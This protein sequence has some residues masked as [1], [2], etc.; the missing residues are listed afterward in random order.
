MRGGRQGSG[1]LT[2]VN[3]H[4]RSPSVVASPAR[5]RPFTYLPV[6]GSD[7]SIFSVLWSRRS[8]RPPRAIL[9]GQGGAGSGFASP[10][11]V[12]VLTDDGCPSASHQRRRP[13]D[14]GYVAATL[15]GWTLP[16]SGKLLACQNPGERQRRTGAAA[17]R[18]LAA[19]P[20]T[21]KAMGLPEQN[22]GRPAEGN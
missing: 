12:R 17:L 20:S 3:R 13:P 11:F 18:R 14:G 10:V 7:A 15:T 9:T 1:P 8:G 19:R 16:R 21:S 22:A 6:M 5:A 4:R 2:I